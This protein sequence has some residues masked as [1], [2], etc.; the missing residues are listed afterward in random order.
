LS[1]A[2]NWV[3]TSNPGTV[4][5]PGTNDVGIIRVG[6][7]LYGVIDVAVLDIVQA[8]G[9]PTIS[10]TGS[11]TQVTAASVVIGYGFTL[12]TG[13]YLQAGA[14]GIDGDGTSSSCRTT[15]FSTIW[16]PT[17]TTC[18]PSGPE[19]ATPP[20]WSPR[21]APSFTTRMRKLAH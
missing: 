6:E 10:I 15:P 3:N 13:A 20:C 14:L 4:G 18:S 2:G 7:G 17:R 9:A 21:G 16:R 12:D 11:S 8:S 1:S 5:T 19:A